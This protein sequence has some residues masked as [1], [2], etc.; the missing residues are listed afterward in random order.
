VR[1]RDAC[2]HEGNVSGKKHE[3]GCRAII[4]SPAWRVSEASS[5]KST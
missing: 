5:R 2:T 3:T 1:M 4:G